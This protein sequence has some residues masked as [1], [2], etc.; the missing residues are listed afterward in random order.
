M[1][2]DYIKPSLANRLPLYKQIDDAIGGW[3]SVVGAKALYLPK[4][5]SENDT[6]YAA[7][8]ALATY[9]DF[10]NPTIDGIKGALL[11]EGVKLEDDVPDQLIEWLENADQTGNHFD[12]LINDF[13]DIALNKAVSFALI[14]MPKGEVANRNDEIQQGIRPYIK[15]INPEDITSFK[16]TIVNGQITLSQVKIREYHEE[17]T[18]EY[19]TETVIKYRVLTVGAWELFDDKGN[20]LD[21]GTNTLNFIPLVCLNLENKSFFEGNPLYYDLFRLNIRHYQTLS[22]ASYAAHIASVPFYFGSGIDK[23]EVKNLAISP[24]TFFATHNPDADI[25]IIDYDGKGVAVCQT[26]NTELEK[27]MHAIGFSV[28]MESK[29]MTATETR[30]AYGQKQS[31]LNTYA[32]LL[33]DAIENIFKMM[34]I[35]GGLGNDG[36]SVKIDSDILRSPLDAQQFTTLVNAVNSGFISYETG[37]NMILSGKLELPADFAPDAELEKINSDGLLNDTRTTTSD[38]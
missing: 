4:Q 30:L 10:Y 32:I 9:V 17:D 35:M 24:N 3:L 28:V 6:K 34:A 22:D 26:I 15:I 37:W 38:N 8:H 11:K 23:D 19:A 12:V 33:R 16:T 29:E 2:I 5:P 1:A 14:D 18:D 7:R 36:G 13:V 31:K 27:Q 20:S 25:K 21:N